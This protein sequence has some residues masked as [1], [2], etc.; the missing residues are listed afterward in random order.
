MQTAESVRKRRRLAWG[1]EN[2]ENDGK[3][4]AW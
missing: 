2:H 4:R 1:G 3:E